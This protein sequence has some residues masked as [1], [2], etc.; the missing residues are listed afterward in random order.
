VRRVLGFGAI[1]G[2]VIGVVAGVVAI[3]EL[4]KGHSTVTWIIT[5]LAI[6]LVSA[7]LFMVNSRLGGGQAIYI[8]NVNIENVIDAR[9]VVVQVVP[10]NVPAG[11]PAPPPGD[12]NEPS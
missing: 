12:S 3:V 9:S 11:A 2:A 7:V 8:E 1:V 5:A 10:G 6:L 4:L